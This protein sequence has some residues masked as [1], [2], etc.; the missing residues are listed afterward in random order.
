MQHVA[1]ADPY[2][3]LSST[4][5]AILS[6]LYVTDGRWDDLGLSEEDAC[7][8]LA[9]FFHCLRG[10]VREAIDICYG[11]LQN[12]LMARRKDT[13]EQIQSEPPFSRFGEANMRALLDAWMEGGKSSVT[14]RWPAVFNG[15]WRTQK[16]GQLPVRILVDTGDSADHAIRI[17]DAGTRDR[18]KVQSWYFNYLF[19]KEW[20]LDSLVSDQNHDVVDISLP[21]HV[22]RRFYFER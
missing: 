20:K 21:N 3:D 5:L 10:D 15:D 19:G 4:E 13:F 18:A 11:S 16:Q 7:D 22:R 1:F 14:A 8:M 17:V 6:A 12:S 9:H 2:R